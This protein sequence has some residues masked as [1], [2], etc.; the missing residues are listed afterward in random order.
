V[1]SGEGER[2]LEIGFS[3][4]SHVR[5]KHPEGHCS[6]RNKPPAGSE[7]RRKSG[8]KTPLLKKTQPTTVLGSSEGKETK[9]QPKLR[10][11]APD[12]SKDYGNAVPNALL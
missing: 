10:L 3:L 12:A 7:R 1:K 9:K 11:V 6:I 8:K 4:Q 5:E 2:G